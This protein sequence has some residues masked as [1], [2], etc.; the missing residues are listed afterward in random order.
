MNNSR[1]FKLI[2]INCYILQT[3]IKTWYHRQIIYTILCI[4]NV[5]EIYL[6]IFLHQRYINIK[7]IKYPIF[8]LLYAN[9]QKVEAFERKLHR[10]AI[11][12][13]CLIKL[14]LF[15]HLRDISA[16]LW[17]AGENIRLWIT[18]P[19]H[20]RF[21]QKFV[22]CIQLFCIVHP[23]LAVRREGEGANKVPMG[24]A[25]RREKKLFTKPTR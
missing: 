17:R 2:K 12:V 4:S 23:C 15:L 1:P 19:A 16:L 18:N 7:C 10:D 24:A 14:G 9:F 25:R 3:F 5:Y 13:R 21:P 20:E 11:E 6:Y 22:L 8:F